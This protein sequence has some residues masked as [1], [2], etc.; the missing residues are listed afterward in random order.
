[1]TQSK[2]HRRVR[3]KVR[4]CADG[5]LPVVLIGE[6]PWTLGCEASKA[7]AKATARANAARLNKAQTSV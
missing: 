3:W 7:S 5:W 6:E 1:M 2:K 4:R